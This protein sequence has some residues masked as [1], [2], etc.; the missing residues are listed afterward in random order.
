[1]EGE[2]ESTQRSLGSWL[3]LAGGPVAA[4]AVMLVLWGLSQA[5]YL[6]QP[7]VAPP[8]AAVA[9]ESNGEPSVPKPA[10][11]EQEQAVREPLSPNLIAMAGVATLMAVWWL[12][13]VVP[14]AATA[15]IPLAVFPLAGILPP[16]KTA[17]CYGDKNIFL[18][19]GG[20]LVALAVEESGLHRRVALAIVA[21]VGDS[22]ARVVLGFMLATGLLSMWLSNTA[23]T[24][25]M[26]PIALSILVEAEEHSSLDPKAL[27]NFGISLCLAVAYAASIGGMGTKVG[28]PTNLIFFQV[29]EKN[30]TGESISFFEWMLL[31]APL[32]I[33]FLLT[34]WFVIA[35]V[36]FPMGSAPL[37]GGSELI[38]D[39]RAKLGPLKPYEF[40]VG[41]IFGLTALL[42]IVRDPLLL[43][44]GKTSSTMDD[45]TIAMLAALACF[46]VPSEG[47][48]GRPLLTW[49]DT[50]R[51]PWG[52][53][54]LF[55]GGLALASGMGAT[56]L[57]HL[58]G[59]GMGKTLVSLPYWGMI[60]M[61]AAGMTFFSEITS[62]V[63][64]AQIMLPI[65]ATVAKDQG[66]P[67]V[68][69]MI[70]ATLAASCGFM[71]PVATPPNA[72]AYGTG[73]LKVRDMARAGIWMNLIG[74][75]LITITVLLIRF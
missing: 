37:L 60:L 10:A 44:L 27:R 47:T 6:Y 23:T 46:L 19:L 28:T 73:R 67:P 62:N 72:I 58:A 68:P 25:M 49:K 74:I 35:K 50:A 1:M 11:T 9:P 21:Q 30:F 51:V 71:L 33:V 52:I 38:R 34:A 39:L 48:A 8:A 20:F 32:V 12:T 75:V 15:L 65:L 4:I 16:D 29:Y 26:L 13:E 55:G 63:A 31:A 7:I 45:S 61:V 17:L 22:P 42:W 36:L 64:C 14:M 54:L 18:Y 40:R 43:L 59:E 66:L 24:L 70:A 2:S 69:L 56:H 57:D 5:G 3:A 41:L 53:L